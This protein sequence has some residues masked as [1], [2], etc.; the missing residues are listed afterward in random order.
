MSEARL[1]RKG[2]PSATDGDA[3]MFVEPPGDWHASPRKTA[4][5][6]FFRVFKAPS[7][8]RWQNSQSAPA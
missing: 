1:K 7:G 2:V 6:D 3:A 4:T 8:Q 5:L